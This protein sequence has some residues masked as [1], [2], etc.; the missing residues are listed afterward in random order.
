MK[1]KRAILATALVLTPFGFVQPST[2][3]QSLSTLEVKDTRNQAV[4]QAIEAYMTAGNGNHILKKA[5]YGSDEKQPL[6]QYY[7]EPNFA[8]KSDYAKLTIEQQA[9]F[10]YD[11]NEYR[12]AAG[13]DWE[14]QH[15][16]TVDWKYMTY[17][18]Q[19]DF[20]EFYWLRNSTEFKNLGILDKSRFIHE[21]L[22]DAT[23]IYL[24]YRRTI[25]T[26]AD[27]VVY[28]DSAIQ[29]LIKKEP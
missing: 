2:Q 8:F 15:P 27:T 12:K 17:D 7:L 13:L 14:T 24:A 16:R 1:V 10:A 25:S 20:A 22:I 28:G 18:R 21:S 3:G 29:H 19:H 9:N 23:E 5:R 26:S 6:G 11:L 4:M